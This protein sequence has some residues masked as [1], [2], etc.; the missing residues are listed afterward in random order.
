MGFSSPSRCFPK[1]PPSASRPWAPLLGFPSPTA[2]RGGESPRPGFPG[3]TDGSHPVDYGAARRFSQ[4]LSGF[5]LSP[6]SCHFQAGGARGVH[7]TGDCSFHEA[8]A[9]RRRRH[10]LLTFLLR[11]ALSPFLGGDVRRRAGSGLGCPFQR[12]CRLQGVRP[13]GNRSSHLFTVKRRVIDLPLLGFCLLMVCT[14]ADGEGSPAGPSSFTTGSPSPDR[15]S[16]PST[17]CRPHGPALCSRG[18]SHPKVSRLRP[19][20]PP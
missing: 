17:A 6:P 18:P 16:L 20:T 14:R 2:L 9:T 19:L 7:P 15:R 11:V 12:L 4:P 5:F 10:T 13:R 1:S 8:P 3:S